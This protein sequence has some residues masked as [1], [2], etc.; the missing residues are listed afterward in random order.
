MFYTFVPSEPTTSPMKSSELSLY[1]I[2][3][4][5]DTGDLIT[6]KKLQK[7]YLLYRSMVIGLHEFNR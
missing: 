1:V 5:Y 3:K 6:N 2:A 4:F 7:A